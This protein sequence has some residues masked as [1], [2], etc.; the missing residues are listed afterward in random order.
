MPALPSMVWCIS[1]RS[2]AIFSVPPV[3]RRKR[4]SSRLPSS[5]A[6]AWTAGPAGFRAAAKSAAARP[7]RAPKTSS[8]VSEFDPRRLAPLMLTHA[9]SPAA[10]RPASGVAPSMSVEIPPIM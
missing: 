10:Y 1:V 6:W 8:S 4:S 7:A 5:W 2:V 3:R 9:A